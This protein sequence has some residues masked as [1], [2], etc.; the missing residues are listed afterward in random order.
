ML[1]VGD[2]ALLSELHDLLLV[3]WDEERVPQD[4]KNGS[5]VTIFK[6]QCRFSNENY[7]GITLL[8]VIGKRGNLIKKIR[9]GDPPFK[10]IL[11]FCLTPGLDAP[12]AKEIILAE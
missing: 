1:K 10:I 5:V 4:M 8:S 3:I 12:N 11:K 6:K 2:P 7:R 9:A